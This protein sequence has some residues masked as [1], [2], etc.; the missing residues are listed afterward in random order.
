MSSGDILLVSWQGGC[1]LWY[2]R[3]L[4]AAVV[5]SSYHELTYSGTGQSEGRPHILHRSAGPSGVSRLCGVALASHP[6]NPV[7]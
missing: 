7:C 2:V 6:A 1:V 3:H 4:D 5:Y